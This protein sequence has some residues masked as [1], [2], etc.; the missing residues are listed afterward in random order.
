MDIEILQFDKSLEG[1]F[2]EYSQ[3][4]INSK[5]YKMCSEI[6]FIWAD[7]LEKY[8]ENCNWTAVWK[9]S[10]ELRYETYM[11]SSRMQ[12]VTVSNIYFS[13]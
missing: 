6:K 3:I 12:Y 7:Y 1:R 8:F 10:K 2:K 5:S 9:V 13:K 11:I 4:F